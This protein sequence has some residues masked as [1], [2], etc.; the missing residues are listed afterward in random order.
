MIQF[1]IQSWGQ[2]VVFGFSTGKVH[3]TVS[4]ACYQSL[5]MNCLLS[6][7]LL[8]GKMQKTCRFRFHSGKND[9]LFFCGQSE[10]FKND[11]VKCFV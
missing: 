9:L 7:H 10:E 11:P 8:Y 1:L 3:Q 6:Q 4:G 2:K 5:H